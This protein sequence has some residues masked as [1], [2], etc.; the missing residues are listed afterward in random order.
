MKKDCRRF[1]VRCTDP[2]AFSSTLSIW[3]SKR[4]R[5]VSIPRYIITLFFFY[6]CSYAKCIFIRF[7]YSLFLL[8][9]LCF[10]PLK[11]LLFVFCF[12]YSHILFVYACML[13]TPVRWFLRTYRCC[14]ALLFTLY[15]FIRVPPDGGTGGHQFS[16][17][18]PGWG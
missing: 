13:F 11:V 2:A 5:F 17:W 10:F 12:F 8:F 3:Q 1:S 6:L 9:F 18:C 14:P 4:L 7:L 16:N 15:A